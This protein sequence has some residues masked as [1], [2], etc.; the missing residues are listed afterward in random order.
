MGDISY[1][2]RTLRKAP[3]ASVT[4]V[5]TIA[6][7]LGMVAAVFTLLNTFL[8]RFDNVPNIHEMYGIERPRTADGDLVPVTRPLYDAVRRETS[9]FTDVFAMVAETD[10]RVNG[11]TMGGS[12]RSHTPGYL[13]AAPPGRTSRDHR[14]F[15]DLRSSEVTN[16]S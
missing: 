12:L 14:E 1:A 11:R 16:E 13:P 2:F 9:V 3:L 6:L 15:L 4:I 8:F 7:G 5:V 10:S